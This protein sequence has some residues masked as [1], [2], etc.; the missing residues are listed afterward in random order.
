VPLSNKLQDNFRYQ[1]YDKIRRFRYE[2]LFACSTSLALKLDVFIQHL[3]VMARNN[4]TVVEDIDEI[5]AEMEAKTPKPEDKIKSFSE[6]NEVAEKK[7]KIDETATKSQE[8][9]VERVPD[10][11]DAK[12]FW[13][14]PSKPPKPGLTHPSR[15]TDE[16]YYDFNHSRVGAAI[17]F[18][19]MK[20][21]GEAERKGSQK[22]SDDFRKV[23][24][25]IGFEV[26]ICNDFTIR[27]IKDELESC[28]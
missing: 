23:L 15:P 14:T 4:L 11:V 2:F 10:V 25:E 17:I 16:R 21:K 1:N 5:M 13:S 18:N 9:V 8:K 27:Q 28:M 20:I 19:Q 7:Q 26:K 22:D 12:G 6:L 3:L 24:F